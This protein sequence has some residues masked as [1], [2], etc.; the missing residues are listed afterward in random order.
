MENESKLLQI[1]F[2]GTA[3]IRYSISLSAQ[4]LSLPSGLSATVPLFISCSVQYTVNSSQCT[5]DQ[6][7]MRM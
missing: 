3:K 5:R 2:Q 1:I 6:N 7:Y 4:P